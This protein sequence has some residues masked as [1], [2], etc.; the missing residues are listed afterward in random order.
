MVFANFEYF[1]ASHYAKCFIF[2]Y[3]FNPSNLLRFDFGSFADLH[4]TDEAWRGQELTWSN[5]SKSQSQ[6]LNLVSCVPRHFT[7]LSQKFI[8]ENAE[9]KHGRI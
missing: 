4:F 1:C 3:S 6:D 9:F 5:T 8:G 7:V 2:I